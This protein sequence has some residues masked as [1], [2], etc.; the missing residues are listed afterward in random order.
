MVSLYGRVLYP[1]SFMAFVESKRLFRARL[2]IENRVIIG[3]VPFFFACFSIMLPIQF[4]AQIGRK[5]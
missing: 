1:S 3:F 2:Q 5:A 4:A